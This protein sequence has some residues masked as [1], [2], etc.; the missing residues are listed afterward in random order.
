MGKI[1]APIIGILVLAIVLLRSLPFI[2]L[3]TKI[4]WITNIGL[5]LMFV[6]GGAALAVV[7]NALIA[8][9]M[10]AVVFAIIQAL[11]KTL[12]QILGG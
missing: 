5:I 9:I 4:E 3:E 2:P 11:L 6:T 8:A 10:G 7:K 12:P 1:L